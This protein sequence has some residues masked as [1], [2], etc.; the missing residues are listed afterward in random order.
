VE[1]LIHFEETLIAPCAR[2]KHID[3]R[4]RTRYKISLIRNLETIKETGMTNYLEKEVRKW[5]CPN[6]GS[7]VSVHRDNC[8]KCNFD[9]KKEILV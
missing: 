2:L 4:Y 5:S 7:V 1:T 9:L 3:Q 6:C 8:I